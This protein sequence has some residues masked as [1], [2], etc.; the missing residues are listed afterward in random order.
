MLLSRRALLALARQ[1]ARAAIAQYE[2][3]VPLLEASFGPDDRETRI[4][5]HNLASSLTAGF[6]YEEALALLMRIAEEAGGEEAINTPL[7]S[8]LVPVLLALG[9]DAE[10]LRYGRRAL[11]GVPKTDL[12]TISSM[13]QQLQAWARAE[14]AAGDKA[15]VLDRLQALRA[16]ET[17]GDAHQLH[18]VER[19]ALEAEALLAIGRD[20]PRSA[21]S[22]ALRALALLHSVR[23]RARTQASA[24]ARQL[25]AKARAAALLELGRPTE[26]ARMLEVLPL[27][28][29]FGLD[30]KERAEAWV[31]VAKGFERAG[32]RAQAAELYRRVEPYSRAGASRGL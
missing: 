22:L 14:L 13:G 26:A 3:A 17:Y 30:P 20:K 32:Q 29:R 2:R 9:R 24:E 11:E 27:D 25:W 28:D 15:A 7:A 31:A 10:A 5:L 21:R 12:R 23:G 19:R 1:D 16:L 8:D 18:V 4:A 6:R